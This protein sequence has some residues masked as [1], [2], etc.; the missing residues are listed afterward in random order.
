M[1]QGAPQLIDSGKGSTTI[2][3][4]NRY[5]YPSR[6]PRE[7]AERR[8]ERFTIKPQ[9]LAVVCSPLLLYGVDIL[10][11]KLPVDSHILAIETDQRLMAMLE[12]SPLYHI[13][14]DKR[15][16]II[17]SSSPEDICAYLQKLDI[18]RFRRACLITLNAG[19][20]L[21]ADTYRKIYKS[22]EEEIQS[23]WQN[24]ATLMHMGPLWIRNI[25]KN[26]TENTP[27]EDIEGL[28]VNKPII[29]TGAGESLENSIPFIKEN[30]KQV[31]VLAV[32]TALPCLYE[33]DIMPD[34]VCALDAQH[35]NTGDFNKNISDT[36]PVA[37]DLSSSP[38]VPRLLN[39]KRYVFL[40][41]F[42]KTNLF[43]QLKDH[44]VLPKKI[45]A[46]GSVGIVAIDIAMSLTALPVFFTGLDFCYTPGKPHAKGALTH[47]I[48][49]ERHNRFSALLLSNF[50]FERQPKLIK[51]RNG[52]KKAV[53]SRMLIFHKQFQQ[54]ISF[55]QKQEAKERLYDI[56][57]EGLVSGAAVIDLPTASQI[58]NNAQNKSQSII[59][60]K[61]KAKPLNNENIHGFLSNIKKE[62]EGV[63][64]A[65]Y[66]FLSR[67]EQREYLLSK[68]SSLDWLY[69]HFPEHIAEPKDDADF[70]KRCLM[71]VDYYLGYI[72]K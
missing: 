1:D 64:T 54:N 69:L 62:L 2:F 8:A 48:W 55:Y 46:L 63:R 53:D 19:Y 30:K 6:A 51:D 21:Y 15:I 47:R 34:L 11:K 45:P 27:I 31:F 10:L 38:I 29:V 52:E 33:N 58:I 13:I 23:F 20:S 71:A 14:T 36:I 49:L 24:K 37:F 12:R 59:S 68:L 50:T 17:R 28:K 22:I 32:D 7:G 56:A 40:S 43:Q 60:D 9:T 18:G 35:I 44:A 67:R 25:F 70:I 57:E 16:N 61:S 5:L 4:N 42:A 39:G 3:Y 72:K 65:G 66:S 41:D 26:F